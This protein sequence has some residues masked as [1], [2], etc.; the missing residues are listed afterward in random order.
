[1]N[2]AD[3]QY[4]NAVKD[5]LDNGYYA[6]NRTGIPTKKLHGKFFQF[7]LQKEFPILTTK[8]VFF[9]TAI[10][11]VQW[12]Y[13]LG[14]NDVKK[15]QDMNVHIWDEWVKEDG[16]IGK[17]YGYQ[18]RSWGG[19]IDQVQN[20]I[21]TLKTNPQSRR[22]IISLWNVTDLPDMALE[23]CTFLTMWDVMGDILNM[24][25]IQR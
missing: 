21:D 3:M 5:I 22:M 10:K 16:T 13:V 14:S 12:M 19:N 8:K 9:K 4:L 20:L 7:D 11:E 1:M 2:N 25:L 24:T 17:A 15:L 23:P 6:Q 18:A